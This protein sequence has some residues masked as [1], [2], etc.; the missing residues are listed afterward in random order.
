MGIRAG[1]DAELVGVDALG[2]LPADSVDQ[3]ITQITVVEFAN[4]AA[5][6]QHVFEA[7]FEIGELVVGG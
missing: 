1:H 7:R 6:A 4:H 3:G 5:G 2:L